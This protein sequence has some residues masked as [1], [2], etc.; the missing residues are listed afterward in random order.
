MI[1]P[2]ESE[3][4][5]TPPKS[6]ELKVPPRRAK[7]HRRKES[8]IDETGP[9]SNPK[10]EKSGLALRTPGTGVEATPEGERLLLAAKLKYRH[11]SLT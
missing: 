6:K 1:I 8:W 2:Q 4:L 9:R 7:R 5:R 11:F 10:N 3:E